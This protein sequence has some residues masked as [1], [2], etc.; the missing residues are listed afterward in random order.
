MSAAEG[1]G[2]MP[3]QGNDRGMRVECAQIGAP[4]MMRQFVYKLAERMGAPA[5]LRLMSRC[6]ARRCLRDV[7]SLCLSLARVSHRNGDRS[8]VTILR[9]RRRPNRLKIDG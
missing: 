1:D 2:A 8:R 4:G 3:H 7:L 6:A 9:S 5:P